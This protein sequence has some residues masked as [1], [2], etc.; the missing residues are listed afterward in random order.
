MTDLNRWHDG[1]KRWY[2]GLKRWHDGLK[3]WHDDLTRWHDGL[4][5]RDFAYTPITY[6]PDEFPISH[7]LL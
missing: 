5:R 2:D 1:L 4:N 6:F 7:N 3:R